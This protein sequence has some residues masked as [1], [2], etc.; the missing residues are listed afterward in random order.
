LD[1]FGRLGE[2]RSA[3]GRRLLVHQRE[4]GVGVLE[5]VPRLK[6][7]R[8]HNEVLLRVRKQTLVAAPLALRRRG[9]LLLL[10]LATLLLLLVE[11]LA[12]LDDWRLVE[13][14]VLLDE[15]VVA[16][17]VEELDHLIAVLALM[18]LARGEGALRALREAPDGAITL[19][20][21]EFALALLLERLRIRLAFRHHRE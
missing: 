3:K 21:C 9:R 16:L 6:L 19:L 5:N 20:P 14:E 11:L 13:H 4:E 18:L 17:L 10:E 12:L 15:L 7:A 8:A 2:V 1:N